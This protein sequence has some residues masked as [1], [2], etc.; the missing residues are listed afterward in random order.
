[1]LVN[2]YAI[3]HRDIEPKGF[4]VPTMDGFLT[5]DVVLQVKRVLEDSEARRQM[6]EH[7]YRVAL[8]HFSYA[9]L[10]Q[11]LRMLIANAASFYT[12]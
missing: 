8:Q 5:Q 6:V 11:R 9:E 12:P 2:R 3:F 1:M 4:R 10:R 7:N